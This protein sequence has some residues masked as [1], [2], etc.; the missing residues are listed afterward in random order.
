MAQDKA[1]KYNKFQLVT[2]DWQEQ[3]DDSGDAGGTGTDS[4][5]QGGFSNA[6]LD[7]SFARED[8]L[9]DAEK[10]LLEKIKHGQAADSTLSE[11]QQ[12]Q[13][14]IEH[15]NKHEKAVKDQKDRIYIYDKLRS[16]DYPLANYY[17]AKGLG[18]GAGMGADASFKNH[19]A[20]MNSNQFNGANPNIEL[21]TTRS[22]KV[23]NEAQRSENEERLTLQ[24]RLENRNE[25]RLSH[26]S[27]PTLTM[28]KP[29]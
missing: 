19:P 9:S 29:F 26:K 7:D 5:G 10:Q 21:P 13:K 22:D 6:W 28:N 24:K 23:A 1:D 8:F 17:E 12:K 18:R 4:G 15:R 25:N 16:G 14:L 20:L 11:K 2:N 3:D 27:A